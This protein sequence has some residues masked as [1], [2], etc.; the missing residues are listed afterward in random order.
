MEPADTGIRTLT[1]RL[2]ISHAAV[3]HHTRI[4][5]S[6]HAVILFGT[7]YKTR[8]CIIL[9]VKQTPHLSDQPGMGCHPGTSP[10][11]SGLTRSATLY[12]MTH[13]WYRTKALH[14]GLPPLMGVVLS[15]T[16]L[17][18]LDPRGGIAPSFPPESGGV[19]ACTTVECSLS[20]QSVKPIF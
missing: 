2:E 18:K 20:L 11:T 5:M 15:Y 13:N 12:T 9:L 4:C 1:V 6:F 19:L 16:I 17:Y 8:T 7:R 3:K 14:L 10:G